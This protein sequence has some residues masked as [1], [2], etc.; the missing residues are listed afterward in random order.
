M[1]LRFEYDIIIVMKLQQWAERLS[2]D[3]DFIDYWYNFFLSQTKAK[4]DE[5]YK[6][7]LASFW[8]NRWQ[9]D[10][11]TYV[12]KYTPIPGNGFYNEERAWFAQYSQ[13]LVY[14]LQTPS[15]D[16]ALLYDKPMFEWMMA[17]Y[18]KFHCFGT[19]LFM[20]YFVEQW[21]LPPGVEKPFGVINS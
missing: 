14:E 6:S 11:E 9:E 5:P 8:I 16:I 1:E 15:R 20:E 17:N 12:D 4:L 7:N 21:G 19:N 10:F 3:I 13:Y 2:D 18:H